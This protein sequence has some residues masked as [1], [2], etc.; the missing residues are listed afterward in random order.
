MES[1]PSHTFP[2]VAKRDKRDKKVRKPTQG[3]R[4]RKSIKILLYQP[5]HS[6]PPTLPLYKQHFTRYQPLPATPPLQ[7]ERFS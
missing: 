6:P 1:I 7:T 4:K 2:R 3:V 5:S